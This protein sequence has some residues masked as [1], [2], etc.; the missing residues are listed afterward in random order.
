MFVED[1]DVQPGDLVFNEIHWDGW[2]GD[3][4]SS[5]D[6]SPVYNDEFIEIL[7]TTPREINMS[8]FQI[9]DESDF[10]VGF[11]PGTVIGP[12]ERFLIVDHNIVPYDD[13]I[14]QEGKAA[15]EN[16]DFVM[17]TAN[18]QR[19]LRLNLRNANFRLEL[20]D[21]NGRILDVAGDGGPP[22]WGGR[23]ET[24]EGNGCRTR[25]VPCAEVDGECTYVPGPG[26]DLYN[27]F[28]PDFMRNFSM[29]RLHRPE[30]LDDPSCDA[31][32][33]GDEVASW[34]RASAPGLNVRERFQEC[35]Y[36][37]PGEPNSGGTAFPDEDPDY[38]SPQGVDAEE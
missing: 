26:E 28:T 15:F 24:S 30:C 20:R 35:I 18:D 12:Y 9:T 19:F 16:A 3:Y 14:P 7:N 25:Q 17:N 38:R 8:L 22:F 10:V 27:P 37:T 4:D 21:A 31:V 6:D 29:E 2:N 23:R 34:E 13:T 33:P 1:Q 5:T 32:G 36:A 11:F